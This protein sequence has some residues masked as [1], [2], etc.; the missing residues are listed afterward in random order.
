MKRGSQKTWE[1]IQALYSGRSFWDRLLGKAEPPLW[2]FEEI[3]AS[4]EAQVIPSLLSFVLSPNANVQRAATEAIWRLFAS[5]EGTDYVQLDDLSRSE[6]C[7]ESNA[8]STWRNLKPSEVQSLASVPHG[9]LLVGLATFHNSGYV[10]AA[11]VQELSSVTD[12][13]E[14]P[15]LL[16][17][18]ND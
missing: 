11:A 10:R 14:I 4:G 9:N 7:H 6:L 2:A 3:A 1:L 8:I 15:F 13:S 18:L 5:V 16:V 17:R 12:G